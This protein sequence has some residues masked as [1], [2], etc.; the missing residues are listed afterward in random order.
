MSTSIHGGLV[1]FA[2]SLYGA[3]DDPVCGGIMRDGVA[4]GLLHMSDAAGMVRVNAHARGDDGFAV[5]S[6]VPDVIPP[7]AWYLMDGSPFGSW[8]LTIRGNGTPW[9]LRIRLGGYNPDGYTFTVRVVIAPSL[10]EALAGRYADADNVF[11]AVSTA[12]TPTWFTGTS[13]GTAAA[14]TYV[15]VSQ[16]QASAWTRTIGT[17]NEVSAAAPATVDQVLVSAWM[18]GKIDQFL[19][20]RF[21]VSALHLS[22]VLAP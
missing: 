9:R 1:R 6:T 13:Q 15:E 5:D 3:A 19:D 22:E 2:S 14:A 7:E 17:F 8:P 11:E 10:S 16:A 4:N 20:G 21:I 12:A 18:F